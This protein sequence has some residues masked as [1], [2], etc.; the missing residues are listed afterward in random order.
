[1]LKKIY[2]KLFTHQIV[3]DS[4]LNKEFGHIIK[5]VSEYTMTS[6]ERMFALYKAVQYI[7]KADIKGD[8]VE[9]GVWRGGSAMIVILALKELGITDR[10]IYMYDTYEGMSEPSEED[11]NIS[12]GAKASLKYFAMLGKEEKWAYASL[13]EVKTNISRLGYPQEN[14]IYV[15]G[16]IEET[17]PEVLSEKIALLR[18]D[19]DW[20]D[21]TKHELEYM[22]PNLTAGGVLLIDDYGHWA[23]CKKAIDEYFTEHSPILLN[24]IDYTGRIGIKL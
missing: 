23:G 21:S 8:F 19:T 2:K 11:S 13:E 18:L 16:K 10:K 24:R 12:N 22:Y 9:A 1:M 3:D 14:L 5:Q 4:I 20:Y 6:N 7:V 17:V 15:K